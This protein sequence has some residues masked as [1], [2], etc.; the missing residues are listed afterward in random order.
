MF[1]F[2]LRSVG[3]LHR[4]LSPRHTLFVPAEQPA[5]IDATFAARIASWDECLSRVEVDGRGKVVQQGRRD[6][7][8]SFAELPPEIR[9]E[10]VA[11][12]SSWRSW[13]R[14]ERA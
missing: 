12:E 6:V 10:S 9:A 14:Q 4:A 2:R 8:A 3:A 1:W 11:L 7:A 5:P 13:R